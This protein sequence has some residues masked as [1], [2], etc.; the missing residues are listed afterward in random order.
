MSYLETECGRSVFFEDYS[1]SEA[2]APTMM[3]GRS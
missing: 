3:Y 2:S 1:A